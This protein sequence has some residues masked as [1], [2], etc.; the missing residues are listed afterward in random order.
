MMGP[1]IIAVLNIQGLI[2]GYSS[3]APSN[4]LSGAV[5]SSTPSATVNLLNYIARGAAG[6]SLVLMILVLAVAASAYRKGL[7]WAWYVE[8]YV[9]AAAVA[10][11]ALEM[12]EGQNNWTG[13]IILGLPW[14]LGLVLPYRMF[15]LRKQ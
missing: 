11:L 12:A 13:I 15:F 8:A 6:G 1:L 10:I 3:E 2:Y 4:L 14:L 9:F 7:K 5:T